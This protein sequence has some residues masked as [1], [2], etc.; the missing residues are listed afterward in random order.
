MPQDKKTASQIIREHYEN[1]LRDAVDRGPA[2]VRE[3][4]MIAMDAIPD[5]PDRLDAWFKEHIQK[6]PLSH[7]T[8]LYNQL[9]KAK[10]E[11]KEL[12]AGADS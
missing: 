1:N 4:I 12:L 9:H 6:P 7:D 3:Q 10:E 2:P 11:L 5:D 8:A